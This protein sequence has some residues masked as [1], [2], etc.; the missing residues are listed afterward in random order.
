MATNLSSVDSKVIFKTKA[1]EK[2]IKLQGTPCNLLYQGRVEALQRRFSQQTDTC[3]AL[4]ELASLKRGKN[5]MAYE[6]AKSE[7]RLIIR[8]YHS[9]YY[10][11]QERAV[12]MLSSPRSVKMC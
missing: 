11:S 3:N 10:A 6:P 5:Q 2:D 1:K 7:R 4:Q 12:L 9:S 8:A